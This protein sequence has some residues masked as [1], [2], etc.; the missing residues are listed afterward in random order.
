[1]A[2]EDS[3]AKNGKRKNIVICCDGTGNK[4]IDTPDPDNSN[5]N[6]VKLYAT[7]RIHNDQ[8]GY[9]HPGVGTEGDPR[10]RGK[11]ARWWSQTKGLA[12]AAGFKDNIFDAY[13]HLMETYDDGDRVYLIGFSRGAYTVRALAGLL[14]GYGLLCKGN[15]GH[16]PYA[17]NDY[18]RQHDDRAQNKVVSNHR[19][20]EMFSRRGFRL[21]FVGIWDTV[22][23]VGWINTPLRLFSLAQNPTVRIGR[24]AISIDERR[25]F[26]RDNLMEKATEEQLASVASEDEPHPRQD[27]LQVW[28]PGVHS[29]VGGSYSQDSSGLS[30]GALR[31]LIEEAGKAGADIK[32]HMKQLVLGEEVNPLPEQMDERRRVEALKDLFPKPTQTE[33]HPSLKGPWW[34]LELLPHRYYDKDDGAENW[35]TPL[36][37]RRRLPSGKVRMPNGQVIQQKTFVHHTARDLMTNGSYRPSNVVG[38]ITSLKPV[39]VEGQ[40]AGSLYSY[41]PPQD[42]KPTRNEAWVR[43]SVMIGVTAADLAVV[44]L[45][46]TGAVVAAEG[47]WR[48]IRGK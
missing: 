34:L 19:F 35:R 28:F 9:Y 15:E 43:W 33:V 18:V 27:V 3:Q 22:S 12:F 48:V 21:Q 40:S 25:C 45:M 41:E 47:I 42:A 13:R 36:G 8:V 29:D 32:P 39:H 37:M 30:N 2:T 4:F 1:M 44:G 20:K 11:I 26:Y 38:G 17:W 6:V 7:L 24:H 14:D 16:L 31:W 5:S 10:A 46:L 23:S